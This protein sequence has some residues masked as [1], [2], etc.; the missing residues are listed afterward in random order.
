MNKKFIISLE[1]GEGAGKSTVMEA[2]IQWF[3]EEEIPF[4]STREPGGVGISEKIRDIILNKEHL[5]MDPRTEAL[6]FAAARRQH[7]IEKVLP[8][9]DEDKVVIF[10]RYVDSS[11]VYQGY[12][13]GMGIDEILN[14]NEF[15]IEGL[16]P[17][18]T[19]YFDL[20]PEI[21]LSRINASAD[22]EV[23]RLDLEALDFHQ[24]VREGYLK[25]NERFDRFHLINGEQS[26]EKVIRDV[27]KVLVDQGILR[28]E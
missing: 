22:R 14:L 27:K 5:T 10:D 8:A 26:L 23:N 16:F 4:L 15:A 21:G 18:L 17:D 1:G 7:L 3:K 9:L 25:L 20:S 24:K 11:L 6:L 28:H 2:M 13:R 19:L 12:V